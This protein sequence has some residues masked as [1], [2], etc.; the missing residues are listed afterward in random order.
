MSADLSATSFRTLVYAP[1]ENRTS[2][3]DIR[4]LQELHG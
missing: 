2:K 1:T 4:E 3:L